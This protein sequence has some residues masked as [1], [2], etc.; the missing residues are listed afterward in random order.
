[1][2]ELS[3][4]E[5][6]SQA[7]KDAMR[8]KDKERLGVIRMA[9]AAFKQ[10]EVDERI[11]V[12]ATRSLAIL[13]KMLKQRKDSAAQYADA[14]RQDL[15]DIELFEISVIQDFL[16]KALTE[17][18][19]AALIEQAI[20]DSQAASM[21]DMGK[22]MG[23]LKPLLQGKADMGQVSGLIKSRLNS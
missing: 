21:K 5:Q 12:D 17:Q 2:P 9:L 8:A 7:M 1:M 13:D 11:E 20:A 4:K 22:V 6:L 19:I 14:S 23:L 18:E 16:P 15:A 10:I 3:L